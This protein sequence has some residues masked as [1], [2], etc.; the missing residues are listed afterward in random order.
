M[1][2]S[3]H[4]RILALDYGRKRIGLAL[5]DELAITAAPLT[6]LVRK[7]RAD[8]L[9]RLREIARK[10]EVKQLLIGLPI[11]LDGAASEMSD[12]VKSFAKRLRKHLGLPVE[13]YDERLSSWQAHSDE[14]LPGKR[15]GSAAE[16]KDDVAAAIILRDF[17]AH[18]ESS[19][20]NEIAAENAGTSR[21]RRAVAGKR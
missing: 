8:D 1:A 17:L 11:R 19:S 18:Q 20:V 12:E 3:S 13:M 16:T 7:N 14:T 15:R 10:F 4:G 2:P 21:R 6:V 5:S 9:K